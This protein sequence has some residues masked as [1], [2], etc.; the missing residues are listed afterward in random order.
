MHCKPGVIVLERIEHRKANRVDGGELEASNV[1]VQGMAKRRRRGLNVAG[2]AKPI[3]H[4]PQTA[5]GD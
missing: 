5:E 4:G 1:D 3:E 2:K